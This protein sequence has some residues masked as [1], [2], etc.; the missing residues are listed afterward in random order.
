[1]RHHHTIY[2]STIFIRKWLKKVLENLYAEIHKK[3]IIF[4][5]EQ[6][7]LTTKNNLQQLKKKKNTSVNARVNKYKK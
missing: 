6:I 4:A 2:D 7:K 1:M 5:L 3:I